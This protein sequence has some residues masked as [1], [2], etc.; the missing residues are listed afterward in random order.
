MHLIQWQ[1]FLRQTLQISGMQMQNI[2]LIG[3][4]L[5]GITNQRTI[6]RKAAGL[7]FRRLS[8]LIRKK[9]RI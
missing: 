8:R 3:L 6:F 5:N 7:S 2:A 9:Q 1:G 4:P